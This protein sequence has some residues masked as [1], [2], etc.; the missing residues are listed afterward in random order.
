MEIPLKMSTGTEVTINAGNT[1]T[2]SQTFTLEDLGLDSNFGDTI[3]SGRIYTFTD[4][5][6]KIIK[7]LNGKYIKLL[8]SRLESRFDLTKDMRKIILDTMN[9]YARELHEEMGL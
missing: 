9:D 4:D 3:K 2:Y 6:A 8:L 1:N 7:N 5:Q